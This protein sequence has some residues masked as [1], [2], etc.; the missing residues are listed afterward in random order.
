MSVATRSSPITEL[1]AVSTTTMS[2]PRA[3]YNALAVLTDLEVGGES[4]FVLRNPIR[5]NIGS[6]MLSMIGLAMT[7]LVA[8]VY[9]I[10]LTALKIRDV[11]PLAVRD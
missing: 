7:A 5:G 8:G 1:V 4:G 2:S 3:M 10:Q 9:H 11:C 6:P